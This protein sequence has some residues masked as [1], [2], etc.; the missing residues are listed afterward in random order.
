MKNEEQIRIKISQTN[1]KI[2]RHREVIKKKQAQDN[3]PFDADIEKEEGIIR[4]LVDIKVTL[5]WVLK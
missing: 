3:F 1:E 5:Q 4:S 2:Q